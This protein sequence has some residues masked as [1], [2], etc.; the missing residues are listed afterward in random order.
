[1]V[2]V[3]G[4]NGFFGYSAADSNTA[5]WWSTCQAEDIPEDRKIPSEEMREQL[6]QRHGHWKDP[7]VHE[8]IERSTVSQIYPTW[9]TPDLPTWSSNGLIVLGDAAHALHPTS[10]QGAS[11]ALEDSQ[12]LALLLSKYL[13]A[14]RQDPEKLSITEAVTLTGHSLYSLR[15]SRIKNISDRAKKISNSKRNLSFAVEMMM[16]AMMWV[17]GKVPLVGK[18]MYFMSLLHSV[19]NSSR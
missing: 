3:F 15:S 19:S 8:C 12:C 5:M 4:R 6:K 14:Y 9:T 2:F 16:C 1:M 13:T 18:S 7:V 11:M 17:M 10:G